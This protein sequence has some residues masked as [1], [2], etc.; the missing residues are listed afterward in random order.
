MYRV[1]SNQIWDGDSNF[2]KCDVSLENI[3]FTKRSG[4]TKSTGFSL[5]RF[6]VLK[7]DDGG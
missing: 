6:Y 1:G 7:D 4:F 3:V 2:S 5:A